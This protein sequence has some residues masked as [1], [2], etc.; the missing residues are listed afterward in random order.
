VQIGQK[1]ALIGFVFLAAFRIRLSAASISNKH[2]I[3]RFIMHRSN[4]DREPDYVTERTEGPRN[5]GRI[6]LLSLALCAA[7]V[8][9]TAVESQTGG[10]DLLT[11]TAST[12]KADINQRIDDK[13]PLTFCNNVEGSTKGDQKSLLWK[14]F[15]I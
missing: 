7:L 13:T 3:R 8:A 14:K 2:A 10:P 1:L 9:T 15:D 11:V 4:V 12:A 6:Y 5:L